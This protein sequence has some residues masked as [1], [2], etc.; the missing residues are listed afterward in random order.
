MKLNSIVHGTPT[1]KNPLIVVHGLFG[2]ARNWG[3]IGKRLSNERQVI[4]IDLRNHGESPWS[5][6]HSYEELADDLRQ[7]ITTYWSKVDLLGHSMGGKAAMMFALNHASHLHRLIVADIAPVRYE[8]DQNQFIAA[9]RSLDLTTIKKRSEA[10]RQFDDQGIDPSLQGFFS[11][12]LNIVEKSWR[13]NLDALEKNMA[14]IMAFPKTTQHWGGPALFLSGAK[15]D[16]VQSQHRAE[17]KRLFPQARFAK[18]PNAGHWLHADDPRGFE[19]TV[20]I[21]LNSQE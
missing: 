7:F 16:Y 20:R 17:I 12:S 2:S 19:A 1:Q 4:A 9:M 18:L 6:G 11:Q 10:A 15:S 5:E 3:A 21:F 14:S 8:H 13:L